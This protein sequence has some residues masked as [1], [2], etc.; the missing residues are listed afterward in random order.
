MIE[1]LNSNEVPGS[2]APPLQVTGIP[3]DIA[4]EH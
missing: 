4:L 3:I 1:V 2:A